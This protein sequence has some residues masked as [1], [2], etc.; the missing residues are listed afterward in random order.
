MKIVVL[1][2][3]S[4]LYSS[5]R[6]LEAAEQRGHQAEIINYT[7]CYC[8]V[9]KKG[10][11]VCLDGKL[12]KPDAVIPRIGSSVTTY[13]SVIV[14]QFQTMNVFTTLGSLALVRARDKLRSLQ[15]LARSEID[16]P[17]TA[18]AKYSKDA[19]R[20]IE[21]VGGVPLVIKI[22]EGTQGLGVVLADSVIS[23]KSII[24]AFYGLKANFIVQEYIKEANG[25]DIR[26]FVVDGKVVGSMLRKCKE[27]EFRA[28][29]HRGGSIESIDLTKKEKGIAI[30][31]AQALGL[32][33]AGVD[34]MR[35]KRGTLVIEVNASPGLEGIEKATGND[36]ASEIIKFIEF[37]VKNK[38]KRD[39]IGV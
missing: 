13:G 31:A 8:N 3:G 36:I 15:V 22:L 37:N 4:K 24:Q 7:K 29:F 38:K 25:Q 39:K 17:K 11:E 2:R 12:I 33:V 30:K 1:S 35:S 20:I 10:L 23:A 5:R 9:G 18:F 6:I 32:S 34:L 14:R 27:G 21:S 26:V 28:N 16:I 19:N